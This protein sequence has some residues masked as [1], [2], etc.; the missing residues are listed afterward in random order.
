MRRFMMIASVG[1]V[2]VVWFAS[3][4]LA[5]CTYEEVKE[6]KQKIRVDNVQLGIC[7]QLSRTLRLLSA[8]NTLTSDQQAQLLDSDKCINDYKDDASIQEKFLYE[9]CGIVPE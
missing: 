3:P 9:K 5:G 2:A 4:V 7:V 6:H 1:L 8:S